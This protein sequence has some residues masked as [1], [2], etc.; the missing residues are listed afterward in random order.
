MND[1]HDPHRPPHARQLSDALHGVRLALSAL[2]AIDVQ[3]LPAAEHERLSRLA[4]NLADIA[5]ELSR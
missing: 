5:E 1:P 3:T 4:A 2:K